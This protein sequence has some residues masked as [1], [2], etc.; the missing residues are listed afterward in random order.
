MLACSLRLSWLYEAFVFVSGMRS[1]R[2]WYTRYLEVVVGETPWRFKSS[3]PHQSNATA[4][5]APNL[6]YHSDTHDRRQT[7]LYPATWPDRLRSLKRL[8]KEAGVHGGRIDGSFGPVATNAASIQLGCLG[9]RD[10]TAHAEQ[11]LLSP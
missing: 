5:A 11:R 10:V 3:R 4:L 2:N 6:T 9:Y 8:M 1:W 7:C